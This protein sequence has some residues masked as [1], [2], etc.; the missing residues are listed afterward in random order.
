[1]TQPRR[2]RSNGLRAT[3]PQRDIDVKLITPLFLRRVIKMIAVKFLR[4]SFLNLFLLLRY[5]I[6][7]AVYA[8]ILQPLFMAVRLNFIVYILAKCTLMSLYKSHNKSVNIVV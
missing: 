4:Y 6:I 1:M 8:D 5:C 3:L 2:N 7:H